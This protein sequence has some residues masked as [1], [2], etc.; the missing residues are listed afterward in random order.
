MKKTRIT[1]D[2]N[3]KKASVV[4]KKEVS[5][6]IIASFTSCV[7]IIDEQWEKHWSRS[8]RLDFL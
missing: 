7:R 2:L 8:S 5:N 4:H 6:K 1:N 3:N